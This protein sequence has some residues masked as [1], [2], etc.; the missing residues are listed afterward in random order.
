MLA[1][2]G[3]Q[4]SAMELAAQ[5]G[6]DFL[7]L[8]DLALLAIYRRQQELLWTEGLVERIEDE[9]VRGRRAAAV[10]AGPRDVLP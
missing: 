4:R 1:S 6:V 8:V 7:P 5:L 10:W 9:L 3:D 2:G